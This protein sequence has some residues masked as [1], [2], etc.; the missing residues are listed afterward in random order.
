MTVYYG[1]SETSKG[2]QREW[3]QS[4]NPIHFNDIRIAI[5][6]SVFFF[7][8]FFFFK[9][10][11]AVDGSNKNKIASPSHLWLWNDVIGSCY[12]GQLG[13]G[14]PGTMH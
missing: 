2:L 5:V 7:Y 14:N 10:I 12:V 8:V 6:I 13:H 9:G 1:V 3:D 4:L 11:L